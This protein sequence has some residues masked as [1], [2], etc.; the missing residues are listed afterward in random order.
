MSIFPIEPVQHLDYA[1]VE[2]YS[3]RISY[4]FNVPKKPSDLRCSRTSPVTLCSI[5]DIRKESL[6]EDPTRLER[7]FDS[8]F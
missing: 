7:R 8:L 1:S 3:R 5:F 4:A 2:V 6:L